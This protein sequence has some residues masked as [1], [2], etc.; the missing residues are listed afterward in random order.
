MFT[1]LREDTANYSYVVSQH[2]T[3]AAAE[4]ALDRKVAA[5]LKRSRDAQVYSMYRISDKIPARTK[6][7]TRVRA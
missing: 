7:G 6:A 2:S 4:A 3:F 1:I 5:I